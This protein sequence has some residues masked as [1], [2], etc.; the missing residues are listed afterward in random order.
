MSSFRYRLPISYMPY[1]IFLSYPFHVFYKCTSTVTIIGNTASS[2]GGGISCNLGSS[3]SINNSNIS[4]NSTATDGYGGGIYV[5]NSTIILNNI[6][7]DNNISD[8]GGGIYA[9]NSSVT[10]DSTNFTN[11]SSQLRFK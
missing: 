1:T 8:H 4:N 6:D 10:I 3:I 7:L 9:I 11:N 2:D 5:H